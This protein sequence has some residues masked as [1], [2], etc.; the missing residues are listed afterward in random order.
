MAAIHMAAIFVMSIY[1]TKKSDAY[2][3]TSDLIYG[4]LKPYSYFIIN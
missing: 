4:G 2:Y 3:Y 1:T